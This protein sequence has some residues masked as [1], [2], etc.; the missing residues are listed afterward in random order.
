[1][2][3]KT[4]AGGQTEQADFTVLGMMAGAVS[5]LTVE[6]PRRR[7]GVNAGL[8]STGF[9]GPCAGVGQKLIL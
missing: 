4:R 7:A 1:M 3:L 9:A 2:I 6:D 5:E 8:K